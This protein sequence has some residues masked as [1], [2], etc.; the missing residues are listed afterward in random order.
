MIPLQLTLRNFLSYRQASLDL[1][2]LHTACICG[3]NGAGKSSLL[4]AITWVLWGQSRAVTE[5]DVI[6][7]Q[8][9]EVQVDFVFESQG[10]IYRVFRSRQ[11]QQSTVLE[12]QVAQ[13]G[14]ATDLNYPFRSLTERGVRATQQR[15]NTTL[16]LD[17]E[18]FI[19][20]AYLRQGRADEFMLKRP[21]ERKQILADL[22]KLQ[23]YDELADRAKEKA[24]DHKAQATILE[25]SLALLEQ[26]LATAP[27]L[28]EDCAALE[29]SLAALQRDQEHDRDQLAQLQQQ[30]QTQ[31]EWRKTLTWYQQQ[32]QQLAQ[33]MGQL[34]EEIQRTEA[35]GQKLTLTLQAQAEIEQGYAQWQDLQAQEESWNQ[36]AQTYQ[37][38]N[39]QLQTLRQKYR[40]QEQQLQ[41]QRGGLRQHHEQM[42]QQQASLQQILQKKEDVAAAVQQLTGARDRLQQLD[43]LQAQVTPL[44]QR[45]TQ[46]QLQLQASQ[47]RLSARLEQIT[48]Q[49]QDLNQQKAQFPQLQRDFDTIQAQV[50]HLEQ[51]QHYLEQVKEKGLERRAFQE[52]L[53]AHQRDYE[54]QLEELDQKIV[55]LQE[56]GMACPLCNRPLDDHHW[57]IVQQQHQ[58]DRQEILDL[59]YVVKDQQTVSDREIQVLRQEYREV[60]LEVR[61]YHR[62][63]E[64]RGQLQQQLEVS[65]G[66]AEQLQELETEAETLGRMLQQQEFEPDLQRE[67]QHLEHTLADLAYDDRT[68][69]LARGEVERW[70]WGEIRQAEIH[71]ADRQCQQIEEQKPQV[72]AQLAQVERELSQMQTGPLWHEIQQLEQQIQALDYD[73]DRH[74]QL[75]RSLRDSQGWAVRHQELIQAQQHYPQVQSRLESLNQQAQSRQQ[76]QGTLQQQITT[77]Q[78]QIQAAPDLLT[79][80]GQLQQQIE[81]RRQQR[82]Q[83][84][85]AL[86][87]VQQ[88]QRQL[89]TLDRQGQQQR[90]QLET[91]RHQ[92][93]VHQEL[94]H[95][96]GKNGIQ[97]LLI[98]NLLPQLESEANQILSRLSANQLHVQFITQRAKRSRRSGDRTGDKL[99][100][101]LDICI[102]DVRGTRPY[103]TYSG[104]EAF[105]VNF[106]IRLAL[107]RLLAQRSG[108]AL[109]LLIVDEGFGTQDTEGCDRLIAA[110]NAIA[111]DFA[112]ILTITH[113][114][115]FK[116]AFQTRIE[117][118]KTGQGS[119]LT[120][121]A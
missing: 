71:S 85:A 112:C 9:R 97:A 47:G 59:I 38:Y 24:R 78:A 66:I 67:L 60:E 26:Q 89:E 56:P 58:H 13:S 110:I 69:A 91:C 55:Q 43:K 39:Q 45:Q 33:L 73:L 111:S 68:H 27:A 118:T 116:E 15:I 105:R 99:I 114:S 62:C 2:G 100:D 115:Q 63:L 21:S 40:D 7:G 72:A 51:R 106:S 35:E 80:I 81:A 20:S 16:K 19:N 92:Q 90:Q 76:E 103:E 96:F 14:E 10:Q 121:T 18:T 23:D 5:D 31:Q 52:R 119:Q 37:Q 48:V 54:T 94:G 11:R 41:H 17:Y 53:Q 36:R 64:R 30:Q 82:D 95:A 104:G 46:I 107:A 57:E 50:T 3:A 86:G 61:D 88:Q 109:Q 77:L 32:H 44:L 113:M 101:T 117:V 42:E 87:R 1:R 8:E 49:I 6:H 65:Q 79:P 83:Q 93:R 84:F 25:Q 34:G 12:F 108:A 98:E 29:A 70:R 22:L 102:A 4:E 28:A 120:L 74:T 75:R